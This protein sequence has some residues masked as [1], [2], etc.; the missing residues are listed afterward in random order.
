MTKRKQTITN[1]R[2]LCVRTE[3]ILGGT[4]YHGICG[5]RGITSR[6]FV[7]ELAQVGCLACQNKLHDAYVKMQKAKE[8]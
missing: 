5:T 8:R 4:L 2:H 3:S 7:K 1:N 6:D